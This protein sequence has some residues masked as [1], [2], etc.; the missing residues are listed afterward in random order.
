MSRGQIMDILSSQKK[1]LTL[2]I[3]YRLLDGKAIEQSSQGDQIHVVSFSVL[4][5]A[6]NFFVVILIRV[7]TLLLSTY[8][9]SEPG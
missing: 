3:N 2:A 8:S 1:T 5:A 4:F 6:N 7:I 9:F